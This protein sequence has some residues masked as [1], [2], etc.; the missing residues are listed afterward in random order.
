MA[1]DIT[2]AISGNDIKNGS[3][4]VG[5]RVTGFTSNDVLNTSVKNTPTISSIESKFDNRFD[6]PAYYY[7]IGNE[8][9]VGG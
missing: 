2:K 3:C 1:N 4:V 5:C 8:T 7:G 9:V 6:D